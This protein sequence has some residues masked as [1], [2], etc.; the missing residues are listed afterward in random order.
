VA[1]P[2]ATPPIVRVKPAG[3]T[4]KDISISGWRTDNGAE[5][6]IWDGRLPVDRH[7]QF[8][9]VAQADGT[10]AFRSVHSGKCLSVNWTAK[11]QGA[12]TK[13]IQWDCT[14]QNNQRFRVQAAGNGSL[15]RS[16]VSDLCWGAL[17]NNV[18]N[19]GMIVQQT[20][21]GSS[22]Y[23]TFLVQD[24]SSLPCSGNAP[25]ACG[26]CNALAFKPGQAC[27]YK[28]LGSYRCAAAEQVSC[29]D[30]TVF[31]DGNGSRTPTVTP[32]PKVGKRVWLQTWAHND[33]G[34]YRVHLI[35]RLGC[36]VAYDQSAVNTTIQ[37]RDANGGGF[38]YD[39]AD[40]S[41]ME[42]SFHIIFR[43]SGW[44]ASSKFKY[45]K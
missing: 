42:R 4:K 44:H 5:A 2:T 11:G 17:D 31:V 3:N 13:I 38:W 41:C 14:Y 43:G 35:E 12:G 9:R 24:L 23:Q 16:V 32:S 27:G 30:P 21:N 8:Y 45:S 25:N 7:Q 37:E 18:E 6:V 26:G 10:F 19:G 22:L 33:S 15:L 1:S 29:N 28:N 40:H 39:L 36:G 34:R 20:C